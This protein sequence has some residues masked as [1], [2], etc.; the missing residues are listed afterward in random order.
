MQE[1]D[2][3]FSG[4]IKNIAE[5]SAINKQKKDW[6]ITINSNLEMNG[7]SIGDSIACDGVCLTVLRKFNNSFVVEV[8]EVSRQVTNI[9]GWQNGTIINLEESL[10]VGGRIH[11]HFVLGHVDHCAIVKNIQNLGGS[12]LLSINLPSEL[13]KYVVLKGSMTING[14]SLTVNELLHSIVS[15]NIIPYTWRN[16]NLSLLKV[17]AFV[18][19]EVDYLAKII[20]NSKN[21]ELF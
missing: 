3:M 4:I 21:Q 17:N 20:L 19:I 1:L 8:S 16:T 12:H 11:G 2:Q 18:N 10:E 6:L 9:A 15:F 5:I 13:Q 7:V 14:I